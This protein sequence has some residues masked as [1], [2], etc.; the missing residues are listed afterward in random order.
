MATPLLAFARTGEQ[1]TA[2]LVGGVYF[3]IHL[4]EFVSSRQSGRV[5]DRIGHLGKALNVL[6]WTFAVLFCLTGAFLWAGAAARQPFL[7]YAGPAGAVLMLF[8]FYTLSN[9]R[10]PMVTGFL[11]DKTQAQQRA[12]VLS[13]LS[14]LRAM[15]AALVAPVLG[16][17]ADHLGVSYVFLIGGPALLVA[18]FA[19]RLRGADT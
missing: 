19:L 14:Q 18:A 8:F 12:T 13:V 10:M 16:L 2:V 9:L 1:R 6:F 4:N 11:S 7:R 15:I 5:A 17:I 3:A